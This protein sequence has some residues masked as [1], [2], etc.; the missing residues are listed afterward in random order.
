MTSSSQRL[1]VEQFVDSLPLIPPHFREYLAGYVREGPLYLRL[2][3]PEVQRLE[4][5]DDLH[6]LRFVKDENVSYLTVILQY[7]A[8]APV[9][10]PHVRQRLIDHGVAKRH[11]M[12]STE[13][14]NRGTA[15]EVYRVR[16]GF[17]GNM[18]QI[19]LAVRR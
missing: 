5:L 4:A 12:L 18:L 11:N 19:A 3:V 9:L 17:Y 16:M 14:K 13:V 7:E 8:T 6:D 1:S 10:F 15:D 2:N